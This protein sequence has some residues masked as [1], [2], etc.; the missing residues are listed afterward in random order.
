VLHSAAAG[1]HNAVPHAAAC[2]YSGAVLV[3]NNIVNVLSSN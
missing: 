1:E 2:G 3:I